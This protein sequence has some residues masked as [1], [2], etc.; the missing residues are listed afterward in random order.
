MVFALQGKDAVPEGRIADGGGQVCGVAHGLGVAEGDGC[1]DGA[2]LAVNLQAEA[3]PG[4]GF[5]V[6]G[7]VVLGLDDHRGAAGCG[8]ENVGLKPGVALDDLGVFG[9][10]HGL[11]QH[12]LEQ[13]AGGVVGAGCGMGVSGRCK[14]VGIFYQPATTRRRGV[15]SRLLGYDGRAGE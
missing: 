1:L 6:L 10:H 2:G 14:W 8:D 4:L 15:D 7:R 9:A 12:S 3:V 11:A 5:D 13:G